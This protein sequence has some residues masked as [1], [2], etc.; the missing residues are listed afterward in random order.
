[1]L[2]A[3]WCAGALAGG[4]GHEQTPGAAGGPAQAPWPVFQHDSRHSG[5]STFSGP[6]R[7]EE[8]WEV[9]LEG[10]PGAPVVGAD[11]TI[12]VATGMTEVDPSGWLY[13]ISP[14]GAISWRSALDGPPSSTAPAVDAD[15][16]IYVHVNG[17]NGSLAVEK[18]MCFGPGGAVRWT[19]PFA[20]GWAIPTSPVQSPPVIDTFGDVVVAGGDGLLYGISASGE[21]SWK[22]GLGDTPVTSSPALLPD[23]S[24]VVAD[25]ESIYVIAFGGDLL[26]SWPRGLE[27]AERYGSASVGEDGTVYVV[28]DGELLALGSD[29]EV[30]WT[31]DL[32]GVGDTTSTPAVSGTG[33]VYVA[34]TEGLHAVDGMTGE[35]E[36]FIEATGGGSASPAVSRE[37]KV[38]WRTSTSLWA[39]TADGRVDWSLPL[40]EM[41]GSGLDPGPV[42][43]ADGVLYV[44]TMDPDDGTRSVLRAY[45]VTGSDFSFTCLPSSLTVGVG[46]R[47][48][49]ECLVGSQRGFSGAVDVTCL[50]DDVDI[51]CSVD[52]A[53]VNIGGI[54]HRVVNLTVLAEDNVPTRRG[55]VLA[56]AVSGEV[57]HSFVVDVQVV[58]GAQLAFGSESYW[59]GGEEGTVTLEVVRSGS[60]QDSVTVHYETVDGTAV[61]GSDY[62]PVAG[63]L[64]FEAGVAGPKGISVPIRRVANGSEDVESFGVVLSDP[65]GSATLGNPASSTVWINP[66]GGSIAFSESSVAASEEGGSVILTVS[67]TGRSTGQVSVDYETEGLSAR[68][69]QDFEPAAGTLTWG[70]GEAGPR[71]IEVP[72]VNDGEAERSEILR[73]VLSDPRGG[74]LLDPELSSTAVIVLD[75]DGTGGCVPSEE[76]LCTLSGRF[77]IEV[78]WRDHRTGGHGTGHA[79][80]D[81]RTASDLGGLF[82]FFDSKNIELIVKSLDGRNVNESFWVFLGSLSD[83]EFWVVVTDTQTGEVHVYR[84]PPGNICGVGDTSAFSGKGLAQPSTD[85]ASRGTW[86]R[87]ASPPK[88]SPVETLAGCPADGETLCLVGRRFYVRVEWRDQRTGR[89]GEGRA[90]RGTDNTGYF[91]FFNEANLELVVKVLNGGGVNGSYWVFYGA[92]SDVEYTIS[93][94]DTTTGQVRDYTNEAGNICGGADTSAFPAP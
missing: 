3:C 94:T 22:R 47:V 27:G 44:A 29:G 1:M 10:V 5:A 65:T 7:A 46:E 72:L 42:L 48:T 80:W 93:V 25:S 26:W 16:V 70:D 35:R 85:A 33:T 19:F 68:S 88:L 58:G 20:S 62:S 24:V 12:Y 36:W 61:A 21:A 55:N 82:W 86:R 43:G 56:T 66:N 50:G 74:A 37:G 9:E 84:N 78:E 17:G 18:L 49:T 63:E 91:W 14:T 57:T 40:G 51:S 39:A 30:A 54:G 87:R 60:L 31:Y 45:S 15:G 13:S 2:V 71:R 4:L 90:V 77:R 76:A 23:G 52:P 38:Y 53:R 83:V 41:P 8:V 6:S 81:D 59:V 75:D 89:H 92:L 28:G 79:L 73:L 11:G 67:R 64:T 34:A 69:K 32:D